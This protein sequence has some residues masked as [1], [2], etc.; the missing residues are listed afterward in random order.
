MDFCS[1]FKYDLK[2]GQGKE[3]ELAEMLTDKTIE[4]KY[5]RQAKDTGN[6]YIEYESRNKPSGLAKTQ[7]DYWCIVVK[8]SIFILIKTEELK[9]ICRGYISSGHWRGKKKGGDNNTSLGVLLPLVDLI[10]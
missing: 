1:D 3:N 10:K 6:I 7:A 9:E 8:E 4:V 5:D 2:L